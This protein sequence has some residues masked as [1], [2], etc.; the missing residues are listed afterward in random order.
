MEQHGI[1][2]DASIPTHINNIITRNYV[3]VSAAQGR[4]LMHAAAASHVAA[5][6]RVRTHKQHRIGAGTRA[7]CQ[8]HQTPGYLLA[9]PHV[10]MRRCSLAGAW[11]RRS[12]ASR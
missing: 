1:G 12:W 6:T 5:P 11:C 9:R 3:T 8:Q 7:P 2:T 4:T 10:D